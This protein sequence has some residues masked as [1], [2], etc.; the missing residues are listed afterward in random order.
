MS[1]LPGP[2]YLP[3]GTT[4]RHI[5]ELCSDDDG[6]YTWPNGEPRI[7]VL[8]CGRCGI[9]E[10]DCDQPHEI[11]KPKGVTMVHLKTDCVHGMTS[12]RCPFC[13]GDVSLGRTPPTRTP[14]PATDSEIVCRACADKEEGV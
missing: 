8:V 7:E 11:R 14:N 13:Q 4:Q 5:D 9:S 2:S 12:A 10:D 1:G 3:P 6:G